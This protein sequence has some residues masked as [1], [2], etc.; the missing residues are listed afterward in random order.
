MFMVAQHPGIE[1]HR[2][3]DVEWWKYWLDERGK[4]SVGVRW[5]EQMHEPSR[6]DTW[7]RLGD[8]A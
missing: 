2:P 4:E 7:D 8:F 5:S 6:D 1:L 3:S